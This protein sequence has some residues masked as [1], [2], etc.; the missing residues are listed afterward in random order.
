MTG[1]LF[2]LFSIGLVLLAGCSSETSKFS[3]SDPLISD[4]DIVEIVDISLSDSSRSHNDNTV[5]DNSDSD[6][7]TPDTNIDTDNSEKHDAFSDDWDKKTNDNDHKIND[8]SD[9]NIDGADDDKNDAVNHD[10][11]NN[12]I[13]SISD[14][15][16]DIGI[17]VDSYA[18]SVDFDL[19]DDDNSVNVRAC[20]NKCGTGTEEFVGGSWINCTA[21][22]NGDEK[23]C[24]SMNE[25]GACYGKQLCDTNVGWGI[26]S[27][28][29][30]EKEYYDGKDNNCNGE[31]DEG[32]I[33]PVVDGK[34]DEGLELIPAGA[35]GNPTGKPGISLSHKSKMLPYLWA[36]N[37]TNN[38]VSK[39]NTDTNEE[40]GRYWVGVNPS[41]TAID[42]DG[43]M[44][45]G[46]R[47]DGRLT[48]ILK[49]L[50][51]PRP[52]VHAYPFPSN[53]TPLKSLPTPGRR[54]LSLSLAV[55]MKVHMLFE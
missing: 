6:D 23:V 27:A 18:S 31:I 8:D 45:V 29:I 48:K 3:G 19:N 38:S 33:N 17:D 10:I 14:N 20:E 52:N 37:H 42:L 36:A 30:P 39:F 21:P 12:D 16:S 1:K 9:T 22:S 34:I 47:N 35:D 28:L 54:V 55:A 4:R 24:D 43:N 2:F 46:A 7:D 25:F 26:C 40:Q 5:S 13:D 41:R 32:L 51:L 15:N 11:D 53:P 49:T 44:W 50:S